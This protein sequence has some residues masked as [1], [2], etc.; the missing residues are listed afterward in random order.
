MLEMSPRGNSCEPQGPKIFP[1]WRSHVNLHAIR[2]GGGDWPAGQ[3]DNNVGGVIQSE[4]CQQ[5]TQRGYNRLKSEVER[6]LAGCQE[7]PWG[8]PLLHPVI[9]GVHG[10]FSMI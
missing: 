4:H 1:D 3:L 2:H 8:L 6:F 10:G 7:G 9:V 5:D